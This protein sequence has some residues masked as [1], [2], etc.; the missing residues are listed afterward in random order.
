M[1]ERVHLNNTS[2][3]RRGNIS[4]LFLRLSREEI[5]TRFSRIIGIG[6]RMQEINETEKQNQIL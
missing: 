6:Q 2:G 1:E 5:N 3:R 4:S